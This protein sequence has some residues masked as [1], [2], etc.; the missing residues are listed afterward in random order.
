MS[1]G[2]TLLELVVVT[3]VMALILAAA[4]AALRAL[5]SQAAAA[6]AR[7]MLAGLRAARSEAIASRRSLEWR[8]RP[9]PRGVTVTVDP[10]P[11]RFFPDGGSSGAVVTVG[12]CPRRRVIGVDWLTGRAVLRA[13]TP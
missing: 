11:L 4:G 12:A 9:A 7:E 8:P 10:A 2:F 1:R 13:G 6:A 3:S 5:P